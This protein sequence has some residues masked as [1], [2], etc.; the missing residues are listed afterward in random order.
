MALLRDVTKR[1]PHPTIMVALLTL[2]LAGGGAAYAAPGPSH[3]G[4]AG[5]ATVPVALQA[6][7]LVLGAGSRPNLAVTPSG[8]GYLA[9][10]GSD[11]PTSLQF[12]RLPRG[13]SACDIRAAITVPAATT[14][15]S[16]PFVTVS[17]ATVRIV[18]YRYPT[19]GSGL[20]G[21][22]K[23]TSTNGGSIFDGGTVIGSVPFE[24][25]VVG[26]DDSLSGVPV[27]T[28]M[29]FQN[30]PLGGGSAGNTRAVLSATHQNQATVGL[31][32]AARRWPSSPTTSRRSSA[33]T[34]GAAASMT[35]RTGH[36]RRTLPASR[37]TRSWPAGPPDCSSSPAT[38][39]R[40]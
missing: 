15:G 40:A 3:G 33:A 13:A 8:T 7:P 4:D 30:V 9:W 12:C 23:F 2:V 26:P 21:V 37:R 24:E 35:S 22:Y 16:R 34:T 38:A 18:Q 14:S 6:Q 19:S 36:R 32:D 1:R 29:A 17:G 39:Q 10:N 28:E 11:N 25:G 27:N 20:P 31:V 5:T